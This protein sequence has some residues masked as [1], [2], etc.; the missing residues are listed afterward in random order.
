MV[1]FPLYLASFLT[2][3]ER[4]K[5]VF[6]SQDG[7]A[8]NAK[9]LFIYA[10]T[11]CSNKITAVWISRDRRTVQEMRSLGLPCVHYYRSARGI[12]HLLTAGVYVTTHDLHR[13]LCFWSLGRAKWINLW[14][15][16]GIKALRFKDA[17]TL[18]TRLNRNKVLRMLSYPFMAPF[19]YKPDLMLATSPFMAKHFSD[20]FQLSSER[21]V[22]AEYPRCTWFNASKE[23]IDEFVVKYDGS[24]TKRVINAIRQYERVYIYLPTWRKTE[25]KSSDASPIDFAKL[26]LYLNK[27]KQ[28]LLVKM[29]PLEAQEE[30]EYYSNIMFL[31]AN[32][33]L[34]SILRFTD[35]LI[36]DYSSVYYDYVLLEGKSIILYPYDVKVVEKS[37]RRLSYDYNHYT[38]GRRAYNT[39][40]LIEIMD[41]DRATPTS[42]PEIQRVKKV[43]WS[44]KNNINGLINVIIKAAR[45]ENN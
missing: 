14:H 22:L 18:L 31:K 42:D 25:R 23:E 35:V 30:R 27:K 45:N 40:A 16:I 24:A 5:W 37:G 43:F 32:V 10:K 3:R 7:F 19:Y 6:G 44:Y 1:C 26:N 21:L 41:N 13:S 29:H 2:P 9:Y 4:D 12:Y 38:P 28:L 8:C 20:C 34:Q 39:D 15:G 11:Y 33:N 36:T 17:G